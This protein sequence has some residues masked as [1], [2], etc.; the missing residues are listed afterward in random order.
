[1][2]EEVKIDGHLGED[3]DY[4]FQALSI[5]LVSLLSLLHIILD[6]T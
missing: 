2:D 4:I 3:T 6:I 5:P 1:M